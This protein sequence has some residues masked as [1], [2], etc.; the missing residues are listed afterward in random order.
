MPH[1]RNLRLSVEY[2]EIAE[3]EA[4]LY[5]WKAS[6]KWKSDPGADRFHGFAPRH[7]Y[8]VNGSLVGEE[9]PKWSKTSRTPFPEKRVPRRNGLTRVYPDEE[10]YAEI[11]KKQGLEELLEVNGAGVNGRVNG[12]PAAEPQARRE[13]VNGLNGGARDE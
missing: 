10:D 13:P 6:S 4:Q 7:K 5:S 11:C 2:R 12:T 9:M 8:Y 1:L 3:S